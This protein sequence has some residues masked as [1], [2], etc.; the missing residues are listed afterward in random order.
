MM[1]FVPDGYVGTP[2]AL[3]TAARAWFP[4]ELDRI[5]AAQKKPKGSANSTVQFGDQLRATL[6]DPA[7]PSADRKELQA[8]MDESVRRLRQLLFSEKLRAVY[9]CEFFGFG[10]VRSD[11]WIGDAANGVLESGRTKEMDI[12]FQPERLLV[13]KSELDRVLKLNT[14]KEKRGRKPKHDW[15]ALQMAFNNEVKR[16]GFPDRLNDDDWN[17][18]ADVQQWIADKLAKEDKY[19]SVTQLKFYAKKFMR[20]GD[21][22]AD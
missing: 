20:E 19:A 22:P 7:I 6:Q 1:A 17:S 8:I 11:F 16:R 12:S 10:C 9:F 14:G 4:K 18:Q 3:D 13:F 5:T 15:E 21:N 2:E